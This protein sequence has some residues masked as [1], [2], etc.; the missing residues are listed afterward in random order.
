[1]IL[2]LLIFFIVIFPIVIIALFI[3]IVFYKISLSKKQ[4]KT[5]AFF[6]TSHKLAFTPENT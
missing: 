1:M 4:Q 6:A 3:A 5:F 2:M